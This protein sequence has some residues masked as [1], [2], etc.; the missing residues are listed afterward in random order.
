MTLIK[1][2]D[3]KMHNAARKRKSLRRVETDARPSAAEVQTVDLSIE[4]D[5]PVFLDD[6]SLEHFSP[7]GTT[8]SV[9]IVTSSIHSRVPG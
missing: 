8:S 4:A 9:V 1:K 7:G 2:C 5:M 3:V 6:F